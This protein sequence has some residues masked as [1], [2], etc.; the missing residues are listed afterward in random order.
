M[1]LLEALKDARA[2]GIALAARVEDS[3]KAHR[4]AALLYIERSQENELAVSEAGF[5]VEWHERGDK[6]GYALVPDTHAM[7]YGRLVAVLEMVDA[8]REA[9]FGAD[10]LHR[11]TA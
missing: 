2:R 9:G 4:D 3:G 6:K 7:G 11:E 1:T 5:P 10:T 8:L